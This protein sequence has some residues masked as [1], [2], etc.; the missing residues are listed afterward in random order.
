MRWSMDFLFDQFVDGRRIKCM[1][2]VDD[3][4]REALAIVP[5]RSI[6]GQD[7]T[8]ILDQIADMRGYP[9]AIVSDNGPEFTSKA[10]DEWAYKNGI[11]LCFIEPGKPTQ[12]AYIESFNGKFRDECLNEELFFNLEDTI[13]QIELWRQDYNNNR[14]HSSLNN[15]TPNA[16]AK[17][18]NNQLCA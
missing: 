14:P 5:S 18:H 4:T 15:E 3:F 13:Q 9:G 12:N 16:F 1:T 17:Q 2:V 10:M 11:N 7:V 6:S 8:G